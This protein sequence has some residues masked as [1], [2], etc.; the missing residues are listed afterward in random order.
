MIG[1][2]PPTAEAKK[3]MRLSKGRGQKGSTAEGLPF[4]KAV[5]F[6]AKEAPTE[7]APY[8]E[9]KRLD[10]IVSYDGF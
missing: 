1:H 5:E 6:M 3:R 7:K 9:R 2:T 4:G 10:E 8:R